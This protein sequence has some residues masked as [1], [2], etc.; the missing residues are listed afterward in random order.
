MGLFN[1]TSD[2]TLTLYD[3]VFNDLSMDDVTTITFPNEV[4]MTKT[5]KNENTIFARN[6]VGN[7]A[8]LVLRLMRG[9]NDDQFLQA[10][11]ADAQKDFVAQTLAKGQFVKR[12]GDG[13]GNVVNDV[14]TLLGGV[15]TRN[16][17]GKEN[18]S[19]DVVQAE[20]VYTITFASAQ[21]SIQ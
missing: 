2:D 11:I 18:V 4:V 10:K 21:R 6:S 12:L 19:G 15:I 3:R 9:S 7:N 5:G 13:E 8:V 16:V 20:S 17:D 14:Y 1:V